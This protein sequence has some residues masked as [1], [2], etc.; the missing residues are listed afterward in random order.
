[1]SDQEECS[2]YPSMLRIGLAGSD[3]S[4][5]HPEFSHFRL[6]VTR[7]SQRS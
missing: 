5:T 1:M 6:S 2:I 7:K 3:S 4:L